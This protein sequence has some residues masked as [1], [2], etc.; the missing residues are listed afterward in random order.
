MS[1]VIFD[2]L[3][4]AVEPFPDSILGEG[5]RCS[6]YLNDGTHLPCVMLRKSSPATELAM[7]RFKQEKKADG[8]FR[9][10]NSYE[11]IVKLFVT[12]GNRVNSYDIVKIE[13]SRYAIP[14]SLLRQIEGETTMSWTGFVLAMRDGKLFA[15]GTTFLAEFFNLPNGYA[16]TDVISVHNH[17]YI[18]GNGE[19]K[20]LT[21]G[22][23]AQ[24]SDYDT[25]LVYRERPYF[26][27]YY[28][29]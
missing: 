10:G 15:F 22:M 14:L 28:D 5:Y 11:N 20:S 16:F 21:Q 13:A 9:S 23:S 4:T 24:P 3:K 27:C 17:S 29:T 12:S 2:Y 25:S 19:L 18:S 7:R 1:K 26:V 6:V 8:L